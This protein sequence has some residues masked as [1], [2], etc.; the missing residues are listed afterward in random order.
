MNYDL[1]G[2]PLP[3]K[4]KKMSHSTQQMAEYDSVLSNR[5]FS[6]VQCISIRPG[7][8]TLFQDLSGCRRKNKLLGLYQSPGVVKAD[9]GGS[10][11]TQSTSK[12]MKACGYLSLIAQVKKIHNVEKNYFFN[13][14]LSFITLTLPDVQLQSDHF[15]KNVLLKGFLDVMLKRYP[16]LHYVWKAE[17]QDNGRI[18][19]H[20]ITDHYIPKRYIRYCWNRILYRHGY[21]RQRLAEKGD[22]HAP[23]TEVEAAKNGKDVAVYLRKYIA[24]RK[25]K[26]TLRQLKAKL[27]NA[28]QCL[29]RAANKKTRQ[30][31]EK[32]IAFYT[33]QIKEMSKRKIKGKLWGC[34]SELLLKA[35]S[36][37]VDSLSSN[38]KEFIFS[39]QPII[40]EP[41]FSVSVFECFASFIRSLSKYIGSAI[42]EHLEPLFKRKIPPMQCYRSDQNYSYKLA[43]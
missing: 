16:A 24:K 34:S 1:F 8:F 27:K 25:C 18:H 33:A 37:E 41:F 40:N 13:L 30:S 38:D 42:V 4:P 2:A 12:L 11:S 19:F 6:P 21:L 43:A 3:V 28:M 10:L 31:I 7:S 5:L 35:Y 23:S 15:C 9:P 36:T 32:R 26:Y 17:A 29:M 39:H 22:I 20:I 14:K